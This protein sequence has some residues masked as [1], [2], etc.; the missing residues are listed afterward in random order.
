M[1]LFDQTV[2]AKVVLLTKDDKKDDKR[3]TEDSK[4]PTFK[5]GRWVKVALNFEIKLG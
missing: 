3:M 4:E 2:A 5:P 1:S